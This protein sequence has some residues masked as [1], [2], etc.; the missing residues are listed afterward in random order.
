MSAETYTLTN[1]QK[2]ELINYYVL[3]SSPKAA[4]ED[5]LS[6]AADDA[7][8]RPVEYAIVDFLQEVAS[9]AEEHLVG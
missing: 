1:D 4:I 9:C 8:Y 7:G 5:V 6:E 2:R 3:G